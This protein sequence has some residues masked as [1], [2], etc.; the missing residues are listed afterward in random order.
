VGADDGSRRRRRRG[1]TSPQ[2]PPPPTAAAPG[3]VPAEP[4]AKAEPGRAE[5]A[6]RRRPPREGGPERG[7]RDLVGAGHSQLG[8]S[9]ALRGRD[10]NR[11]SEDDLAAAEREVVIVRRN[12]QPDERA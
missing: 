6:P 3:S 1:A 10:V 4:A 9:G 7:L 2:G 5:R 12:W 8:V 11:P